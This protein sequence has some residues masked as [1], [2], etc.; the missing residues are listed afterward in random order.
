MHGVLELKYYLFWSGF[1]VFQ[2]S[3]SVLSG[4]FSRFEPIYTFPTVVIKH[5][6]VVICS[7]YSDTMFQIRHRRVIDGATSRDR[8]CSR[9]CLEGLRKITGTMKNVR[10]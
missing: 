9:D 1:V 5:W 4:Y 2:M 7:S 3:E 6:H 8:C 10:T